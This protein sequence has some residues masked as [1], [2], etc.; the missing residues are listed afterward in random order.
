MDGVLFGE[1]VTDIDELRVLRR[2]ALSRIGKH[3]GTT[4]SVNAYRVLP[5]AAFGCAGRKVAAGAL[6]I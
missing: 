6:I 1:A 4:A 2:R 3:I 5:R